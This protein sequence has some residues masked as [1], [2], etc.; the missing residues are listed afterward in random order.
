MIKAS[1]MT[2][3]GGTFKAEELELD[4][5]GYELIADLTVAVH[6][7][8]SALDKELKPLAKKTLILDLLLDGGKKE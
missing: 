7:L 6:G 4:G 5:K 3:E 2:C 1:N 8:L